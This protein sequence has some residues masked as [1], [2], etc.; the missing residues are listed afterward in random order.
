MKAIFNCATLLPSASK[1]HRLAVAQSAIHPVKLALKFVGCWL[2]LF[3]LLY[4]LPR[5][6]TTVPV[7]P[8]A[9]LAIPGAVYLTWRI[10]K[11]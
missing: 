6:R 11:Q 3:L 4:Y 8:A 1:D 5:K 2:L 7:I 10:S 9:L